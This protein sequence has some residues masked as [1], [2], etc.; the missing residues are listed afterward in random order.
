M[1]TL[2]F[3][4]LI[5]M[6]ILAYIHLV[7]ARTPIN[8]L[9]HVQ[10]D[11]PRHGILRV[12][13]VRN[14]SENYS[15]INS[16]EKEYS[17]FNIHFLENL[18]TDNNVDESVFADPENITDSHNK[19]TEEHEEEEHLS[20]DTDKKSGDHSD[21]LVEDDNLDKLLSEG[22]SNRT[23][24]I[25]TLE[26]WREKQN[27]GPLKETLSE[28]EMLAKVGKSAQDFIKGEVIHFQE[29]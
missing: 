7:F 20:T 24:E 6:G 21:E 14:A 11:W 9:Q 5:V 28:L 8:C 18:L 4:A 2:L 10:K 19:S 26:S 13:I 22:A 29:N 17:D 15:I 12:E 27:Q 3:Q 16:Y 1:A 23:L 25:E